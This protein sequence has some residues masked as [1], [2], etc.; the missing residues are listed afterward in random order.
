MLSSTIQALFFTSF[1]ILKV[2]CK[3]LENM[4]EVYTTKLIYSHLRVETFSIILIYH[5]IFQNYE[6]IQWSSLWI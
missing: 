6:S 5:T 4:K 2:S 3:F 1:F